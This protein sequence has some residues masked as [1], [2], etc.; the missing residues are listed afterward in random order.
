M[1]G[2]GSAVS[3]ERVSNAWVTYLVHRDSGA[4]QG[5]L[6]KVPV[7]PDDIQDSHGSWVKGWGPS[8]LLVR[9]RPMPYQLVGEVMAHQGYDG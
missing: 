4:P 6:A 8:G 9:D 3:G 1:E 7:I 5:A 2:N